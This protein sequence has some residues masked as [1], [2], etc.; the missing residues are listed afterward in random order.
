MDIPSDFDA[1]VYKS[2]Y[3]DLAM[4]S[5]TVAKEHYLKHG[6]VEGRVY[7]LD[8][9]E[10]F[11]VSKY[12]SLHTDL[13]YMTDL[14]AQVHFAQHGELEGRIYTDVQNER[15]I[16]RRR[17]KELERKR[18]YVKIEPDAKI[19][20]AEKERRI[21]A[22]KKRLHA[23]KAEKERVQ[24]LKAE[25]E[26]FIQMEKEKVR[27]HMNPYI[28]IT[29]L[30]GYEVARNVLLQSLPPGWEKRYIL[31]YQKEAEDNCKVC[32]DG[33][34]EVMLQRNI[35]EYGAW[36]GVKLLLDNNIIPQDS[37]FLFIHDTCKFSPNSKLLTDRI[38]KQ[39]DRTNID[40]IWLCLG[41]FNNICLIR[42]S[43]IYE[44]FKLYEHVH[45]MTKTDAIEAELNHTF[46][47]SPK[48]IH[49][50][51]LFLKFKNRIIGRT[52]VYGTHLR[53]ISHFASI[54]LEK[55]IFNS[56]NAIHPHNP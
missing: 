41:G 22:E 38:V 39:Y 47:L 21:E 18:L 6:R 8:V 24:A 33:H 17:I 49:T 30:K 19:K 46:Y 20:Q 44:G 36:I 26:R 42:R 15:Q 35:Y 14:E 40:C 53:D 9:P 25:K 29:S 11:D 51:Q 37:W 12:K 10:D 1:K 43:A 23:L 27:N 54:N 5:D 48:R 45:S 52:K 55:Y 56:V 13:Q 2:L 34:I 28:V 50:R 31:V 7:T 3:K 32:E 4:M 16:E